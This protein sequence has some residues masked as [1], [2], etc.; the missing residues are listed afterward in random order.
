VPGSD[1]AWGTNIRTSGFDPYY[2]LAEYGYDYNLKTALGVFVENKDLFGLTVQARLNNILEKEAVL[3]RYIYA[4]PRNAS[5]V[6]FH[7]NRRREVGHI[8]N[9]TVKG[10]F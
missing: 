2:R 9:F 7:E 6:L 4:G 3:D 10:N 1:W 8:V 5:P